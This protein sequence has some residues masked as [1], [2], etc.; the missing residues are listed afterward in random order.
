MDNPETVDLAQEVQDLRNE[1]RSLRKKVRSLRRT[2]ILCTGGLAAV[3]IFGFGLQF[4][5][6]ELADRIGLDKIL[7]YMDNLYQEFGLQKFK[8]SPIIKRLVRGNNLGR[9]TGKGFYSYDN[10]KKAGQ[11]IFCTEIR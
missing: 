5:P 4:G 10:D 8:A 1:V 6:F 7:K 11:N 9:K 3:M 2:M